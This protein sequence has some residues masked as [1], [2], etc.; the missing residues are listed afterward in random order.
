VPRTG[1]QYDGSCASP[2]KTITLTAAGGTQVVKWADLVAG[3]PIAT[4]DPHQI[5]SMSWGLPWNGV[6]PAYTVD[7]TID[8]VMFTTN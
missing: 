2:S 4:P 8:N 5:T 1:N 3:Q 6:G 7:I